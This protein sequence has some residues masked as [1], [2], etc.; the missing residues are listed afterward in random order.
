VQVGRTGILTP[1]ASFDPVELAGTTVVRASLHN[2]DMIR[3]LDVRIGDR[4]FIEKAGEIIPQV[5]AVD[6]DHRKGDEEPFTM[7][8]HCPS[9]G[10][11]V[12]RAV[13]EEGKPELE[14]ATRCPNKA[15][16]AQV[17]ERIYFFARRFNMDI[18]HLGG[19]LVDQLVDRGLVAD[20]ADL[21]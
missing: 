2:A 3:E 1:V 14:A 6:F 9:C 15:C 4:V 13:K 8:T 7:P 16:K 11:A 12:V 5:V 19:A 18:D 20:V 17:K 21:Y 10:T